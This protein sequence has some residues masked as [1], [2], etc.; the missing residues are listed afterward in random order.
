[1]YIQMHEL[2]ISHRVP[3]NA[4]QAYGPKLNSLRRFSDH[5]NSQ[6]LGGIQHQ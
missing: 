3:Y 6:Q 5:G 1:M 4:F 2:T